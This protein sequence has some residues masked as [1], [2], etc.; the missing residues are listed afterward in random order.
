MTRHKAPKK[1]VFYFEKLNPMAIFWPTLSLLISLLFII[2]LHSIFIGV[3]KSLFSRYLQSHFPSG[4]IMS[5]LP[6]IY[7]LVFLAIILIILSFLEEALT[8]KVCLN[9]NL[10]AWKGGFRGKSL[11]KISLKKIAFAQCDQGIAGEFL[12]Y[13]TIYLIGQKGSVIAELNYIRNFKKFTSILEEKLDR[14][15]T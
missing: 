6:F 9:D 2:P 12:N 8:R 5:I 4:Q 15:S 7:F 10:I 11:T 13:G 1:E 14:S 3:T